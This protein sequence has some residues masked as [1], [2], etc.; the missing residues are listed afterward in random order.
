MALKILKSN[1]F[2]KINLESKNVDNGIIEF[3]KKDSEIIIGTLDAEIKKKA[4][5][6]KLVIR[7]KKRLEI[8]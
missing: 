2:K 1:N 3:S 4:G 7:E 5:N 8:V 6:Q